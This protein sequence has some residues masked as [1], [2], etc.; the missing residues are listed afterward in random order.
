MLKSRA[1]ERGLICQNPELRLEC[2]QLQNKIRYL[3]SIL[4]KDSCVL[5][6]DKIIAVSREL[7]VCLDLLE[8]LN[9]KVMRFES[10]EKIK[11]KDLPF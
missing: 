10:A 4:H 1:A 5:W 6:T 9:E 11:E 2:G 7:E 3:G 8:A